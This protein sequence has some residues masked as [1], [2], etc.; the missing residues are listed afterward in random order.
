VFRR[1]LVPIFNCAKSANGEIRANSTALFKITVGKTTNEGKEAALTELLNLAQ[2]GK[3]IGPDRKTLYT[4]FSVL[5]TS[6]Q[7]SP[8]MIKSVP[9][10]LA[11]ETNEAALP[12]LASSLTSHLLFHLRENLP[13]PDEVLRLLVKEMQNTKPVVRR[14]F[15]TLV[16]E[17]FWTLGD[18]GTTSATILARAVYAAFESSLKTVATNPLNASAG[19]VEGYVAAAVFLGPF[20]RSGLFGSSYASFFSFMF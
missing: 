8:V 19:P 16:G 1:I 12:V 4:M 17:I 5:S 9:A 11:K 13:I 10:L 3:A 6:A 20:S 15:V 2:A 14:A 18:L 7:L